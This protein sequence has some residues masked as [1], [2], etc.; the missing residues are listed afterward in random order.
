MRRSGSICQRSPRP[1]RAPRGSKK[2]CGPGR[3]CQT[4]TNSRDHDLT[5][6]SM[7]QR[8]RPD[9]AIDP[10][11]PAAMQ[12]VD[13]GSALIEQP[14]ALGPAVD[15][16]QT[17]RPHR[18]DRK[19]RQAFPRTL[20][21]VRDCRARPLGLAT[22]T[23]SGHAPGPVQLRR[24]ACARPRD[25]CLRRDQHEGTP[26]RSLRSRRRATVPKVLVTAVPPMPSVG[27]S[28]RSR[29]AG[30]MSFVELPPARSSWTF[31]RAF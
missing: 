3:S 11:E 14:A 20:R 6:I 27:H 2:A 23:F 1:R 16:M 18:A 4:Y 17:H 26:T 8:G 22:D 5:Y 31:S 24:N 25:G 10:G 30:T 19:P 7:R 15:A 21:K 12:L 13:V 29:N 9:P 28:V